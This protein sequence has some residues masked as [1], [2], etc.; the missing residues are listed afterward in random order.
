MAFVALLSVRQSTRNRCR[1]N[2]TRASAAARRAGIVLAF[3]VATGRMR[4]V[5]GGGSMTSEGWASAAPGRIERKKLFL[6]DLFSGPFRGH[7]VFFSPLAPDVENPGDYAVSERPVA[8]FIPWLVAGYE[9]KMRMSETLDDD[10]VPFVNLATNTGVFAEAFGCPVHVYDTETNASAQPMVA[11][12]G[13]ADALAEPSLDSRA[14]VRYFEAVELVRKELGPDVPVSVPDVQSPFDVAALIWR[15]EDLFVA[16]HT[17]PDAVERLVGKCERLLVN[18][19]DELLRRRPNA[20]LCHYPY[21]WAPNDLGM[22]LSED[23]A[24]SISTE[25]FERFCLPSLTKLS[26]RYGGLFMHCCASADH[27]YGEFLN[28]PNLRGLNRVFQEPGP[29]PAIEAFAGKTVLMLGCDGEAR[30]R[31]LLEMAKPGTRFL[32]NVGAPTLDEA[33]AVY[34]RVRELCPRTE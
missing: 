29:T 32:F 9:A 27:Q 22:W 25:M 23:E 1:V 4:V 17:D 3:P 11:S 30:A 2:G 5:T 14:L 7:A 16:L 21:A 26:E 20:N 24:G 10:A 18:F 34:E 19:I 12:A 28:I 13:E 33:K 31:E 15:K 8:D 6:R